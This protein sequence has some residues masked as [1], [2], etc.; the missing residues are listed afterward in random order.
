MLAATISE[1]QQFYLNIFL[2]NLDSG[3]KI[4]RY[5]IRSL[6]GKGGMGEVY[7]AFDSQL[8]RKVALKFLKHTDDA[9]KLRRFRQEAKAISALNHPNILTIYEVGEHENNHFIVSELVNGENL[10]K[11]INEKKTS[12][13][14]ILDIGIQI[15]NAL[16][17]AHRLNIVHRDIKPEN[18]MILPD[19]YVKVLD[20]GL[21]KFT[22]CRQKFAE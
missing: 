10:R 13:D 15:G 20:F 11:V 18:I 14:E 4:G 16:V 3:T 12:L 1:S 17:A 9:E 21:A 2:M 7:C 5:E 6:L 19:G 22:D 8:E